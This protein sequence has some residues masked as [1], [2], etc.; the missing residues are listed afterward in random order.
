MSCDVEVVPLLI[1]HGW[2]GSIREFY[3]AI[4][5]LTAAYEDSDFAVEV[6]APSLPG[7]GFSSVSSLRLVLLGIFLNIVRSYEPDKTNFALPPHRQQ[8][9][10]ILAPQKLRLFLET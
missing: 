4:P 3:E 6:I 1:L 10:H 5:L 7:F 8:F 2:S 9:D